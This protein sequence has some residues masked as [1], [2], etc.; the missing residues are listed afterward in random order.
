MSLDTSPGKQT[1]IPKA[2]EG[3]LVACMKAA[4]HMGV[5]LTK[6]QIISKAAQLTSS[7][8]L[9]T[10]FK[11]GVPGKDWAQGFL[12]RHPDISLRSYLTSWVR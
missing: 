9:K 2:A 8:K 1:V 11:N 6:K 12:K 10:P 5:G 3:K 4:A 7:M